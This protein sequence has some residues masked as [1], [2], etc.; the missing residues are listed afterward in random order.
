MKIASILAIAALG[1]T[2]MQLPAQAPA[3]FCERLAP[4]LNIKQAGSKRAGHRM[5]RQYDGSWIASVWRV[6]DGVVHGPAVGRAD[7][8][9]L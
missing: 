7:P 1:S 9:G 5:A 4:K 6:V 3:S 8:G 2:A